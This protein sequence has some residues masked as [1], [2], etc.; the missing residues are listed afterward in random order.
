MPKLTCDIS[1]TLAD[2]LEQFHQQTREPIGHIV[3]R[4]LADA[5]QV[6]HA[7]LFQVSTTGALVEGI[8]QGVVAVG[9]LK[10]HGDFGLGTFADLDGEMVALDGRYYQIHAEGTVSEA[11][12]SALVPFEVITRFQPERTIEV[13]PFATFDQLLAAL[14]TGRESGN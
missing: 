13:P 2:Q 7:T 6:E 9:T 10:E 14:D 12:D 1:Q 11:A 4:A 8:Y 3:M 5:L